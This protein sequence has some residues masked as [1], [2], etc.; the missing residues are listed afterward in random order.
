MH[1][2]SPARWPA[3]QIVSSTFFPYGKTRSRNV[4]EDFE[5]RPAAANIKVFWL[6]C[7]GVII[8]NSCLSFKK[9]VLFLSFEDILKALQTT[10]SKSLNTR[11]LHY[12][13]NENNVVNVARNIFIMKILLNFLRPNRH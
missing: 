1:I 2:I 4:L 10:A 8:H 12:H 6:A 3:F 11:Q 9:Q 5:S 7:F 13:N